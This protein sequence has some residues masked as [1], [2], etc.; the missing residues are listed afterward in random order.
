MGIFVQLRYAS[1]VRAVMAI[2]ALELSCIVG[3]RPKERHTPQPLVLDAQVEFADPCLGVDDDLSR[4]LDYSSAAKVLDAVLRLGRFETLESAG[5][6]CLRALAASSELGPDVRFT[7]TL[8]KPE[9]LA[10]PSEGGRA[11]IP[12]VSLT[13]DLAE[14][15]PVWERVVPRAEREG[16]ETGPRLHRVTLTE[17]PSRRLYGFDAAVESP[18]GEVV[19]LRT[20]LPVVAQP[21]A[22]QVVG[23]GVG[24]PG[25]RGIGCLWVEAAR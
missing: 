15:E 7:V 9:A 13:V 5:R 8:R 21:D 4:T 3:M 16:D 12:R 25:R 23:R 22:L 2:E 10:A 6:A 19:T 1:P 14:L 17:T 24:R 20:G 11:P 18:K